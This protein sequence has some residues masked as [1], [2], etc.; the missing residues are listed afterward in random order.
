MIIASLIALHIN[1]DVTDTAKSPVLGGLPSTSP[2]SCAQEGVKLCRAGW[3]QTS[4]G[5]PG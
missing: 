3:R 4:A 2:P 1:R 5:T